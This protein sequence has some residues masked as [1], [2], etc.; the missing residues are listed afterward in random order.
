M[1]RHHGAAAFDQVR[2]GLESAETGR[3]SGSILAL[4]CME[5]PRALEALLDHGRGSRMSVRWQIAEALGWAKNPAF[6]ESLRASVFDADAWQQR[7]IALV[8]LSLRRRSAS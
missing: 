4:A 7:E 3:R 1:A 5:N 6:T 8:A 2:A